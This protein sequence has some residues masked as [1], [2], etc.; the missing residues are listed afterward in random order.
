MP[1][2][3][4][5]A[6]HLL[7]HLDFPERTRR[8]MDST[9]PLNGPTWTRLASLAHVGEQGHEPGALH[10]VAGRALERG[11]VAAPLA[12][13]HLALVGA[14]LLEQSDVLVIDVRRAG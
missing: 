11:A 14:E 10:G 7:T 13:E 4:G 2:N 3:F 5:M 1:M 8:G 6:T 12:R 9:S